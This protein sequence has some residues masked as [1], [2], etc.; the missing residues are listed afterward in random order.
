MNKK[1]ASGGFEWK[2]GIAEDF[3]LEFDCLMLFKGF[4]Q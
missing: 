3:F 2:S 4:A 1:S